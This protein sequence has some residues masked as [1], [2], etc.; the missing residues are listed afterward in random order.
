M[1]WHL[2]VWC[3]VLQTGKTEAEVRD[4][5]FKKPME[6]KKIRVERYHEVRK[7]NS[8]SWQVLCKQWEERVAPCRVSGDVYAS[9][10]VH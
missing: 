1:K 2:C 8:Q 9:L 4:T 6:R 10:E 7:K 5:A 3:E